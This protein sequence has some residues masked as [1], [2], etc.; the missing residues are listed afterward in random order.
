MTPDD[1]ME[2]V[3]GKTL[4]DTVKGLNLVFIDLIYVLKDYLDLFVQC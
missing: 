4:K 2:E 1:I 3:L